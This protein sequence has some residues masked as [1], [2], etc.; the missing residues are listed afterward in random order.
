MTRKNCKRG[1]KYIKYLDFLDY[2]I[3]YFLQLKYNTDDYTS[4]LFY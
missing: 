3:F 4:L 1:D 2:S